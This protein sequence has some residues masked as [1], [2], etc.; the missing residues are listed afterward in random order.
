MVI[1]DLPVVE[2]PSK[3]RVVRTEI[4]RETIAAGTTGSEFTHIVGRSP[5]NRLAIRHLSD[6]PGERG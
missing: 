1:H 6:N 5:S 3:R 2:V 4:R